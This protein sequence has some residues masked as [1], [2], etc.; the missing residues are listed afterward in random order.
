M[1]GVVIIKNHKKYYFRVDT[2]GATVISYKKFIC[3]E[4]NCCCKYQDRTRAGAVN[5]VRS[6]RTKLRLRFRS[7]TNRCED[8]T[9]N[10]LTANER[11]SSKGKPNILHDGFILI[12]SI[13]KITSNLF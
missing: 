10:P 6:L 13:F 4:S 7:H 2:T 1:N 9:S 5:H 8:P 11:R 3:D 12:T